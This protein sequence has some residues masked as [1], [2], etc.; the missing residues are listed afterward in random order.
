MPISTPA[1]CLGGF[2][3]QRNALL[4][5]FS[6]VSS[7][8]VLSGFGRPVSFWGCGMPRYHFD[9]ALGLHRARDYHGVELPD[10]NAAREYAL[11]EIRY[12]N[13]LSTQRLTGDCLIE[14]RDAE[15]RLLFTVGCNEA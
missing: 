9:W 10:D 2:V 8:P 1:H 6:V 13:R 3:H 15:R 4:W 14:V 7:R 5:A 11:N 12:L